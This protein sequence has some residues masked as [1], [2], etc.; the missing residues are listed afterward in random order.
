M[1][2]SDQIGA[3]SR[4]PET[5][6]MTEYVRDFLI[7]PTH[8][9]QGNS[10]IQYVDYSHLKQ[11]LKGSCMIE[12]LQYD[13]GCE[14]YQPVFAMT[15]PEKVPESQYSDMLRN[16]HRNPRFGF[17]CLHYNVMETQRMLSIQVENR[18]GE[19]CKL[20]IRTVDG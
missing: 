8:F 5:K 3:Y 2:L 4:V 15:M 13:I 1:N 16:V 7:N 14:P 18:T 19:A 12:R 11:L 9:E 10:K 6:W 20:G 17:D